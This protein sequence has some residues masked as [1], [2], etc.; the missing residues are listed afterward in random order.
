MENNTTVDLP[1]VLAGR[2]DG[3]E[4]KRK[5]SYRSADNRLTLENRWVDCLRILTNIT[6]NEFN[7]NFISSILLVCYF[8]LLE[9]YLNVSLYLRQHPIRQHSRGKPKYPWRNPVTHIS[10]WITS[11]TNSTAPLTFSQAESF[12]QSKTIRKVSI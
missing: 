7:D 9:Y 10:L 12:I 1:S 5:E 3:A 11:T 6:N 4:T 8:R 2:T